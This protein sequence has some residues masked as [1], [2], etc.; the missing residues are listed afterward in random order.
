MTHTGN[1]QHFQVIIIIITFP[2]VQSDLKHTGELS[3]VLDAE[4]Q[5]EKARLFLRN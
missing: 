2:I 3:H 5:E 4:G 1:C